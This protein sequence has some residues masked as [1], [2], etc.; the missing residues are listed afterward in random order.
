MSASPTICESGC[1]KR[2]VLSDLVKSGALLG[3]SWVAYA[4]IRVATSDADELALMNAELVGSIQDAM[5]IGVEAS[6]QGIFLGNAVATMANSY[7][8]LHFPLTVALLLVTFLRSR[9][10]VFPIVRDG[11]VL[12]TFLGLAIHLV[13][14]LAPPRM[15]DGIVDA[16]TLYGP[17]PYSMPG[18]GAA[19]QFAAMPSMHVAWAIVAGWALM[20]ARSGLFL[21]VL[22]VLHPI[23]TMFV[24][25]VTGHHFVL[26]GA[27]GTAIAVLSLAVAQALHRRRVGDNRLVV[28]SSSTVETSRIRAISPSYP[29]VAH[30]RTLARLTVCQRPSQNRQTS[31]NYRPATPM[32]H[33]ITTMRE[34]SSPH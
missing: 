22:G 6:L 1:V 4:A 12:M 21:T 31:S 28:H 27:A 7:Y 2:E 19:N 18:S 13:F 20:Q 26:D 5:G 33:P 10:R 14:P 9:T 30:N 16:S 23:L 25:V 11:L 15:L 32:S 34:C 29:L 3:L 24:V 17:N 8:L